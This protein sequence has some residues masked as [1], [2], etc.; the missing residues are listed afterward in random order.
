MNAPDSGADISEVP[1]A[2]SSGS[3][4][5]LWS[6]AILVVLGIAAV[7]YIVTIGPE[8][9]FA[10]TQTIA[11]ATQNEDSTVDLLYGCTIGP[12]TVDVI[13]EPTEVRV[14]IRARGHSGDCASIQELDLAQPLGDRVLI[15]GSTGERIEV[16][17]RLVPESP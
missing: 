13:E 15:D 1:A 16:E 4:M 11:R 2:R 5:A 17:N 7:V 12:N 3:R 8:L 10:T 6:L 9:P 14:L